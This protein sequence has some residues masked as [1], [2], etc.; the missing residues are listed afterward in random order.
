V[1]QTRIAEKCVPRRAVMRIV[2]ASRM[3]TSAV[4]GTAHRVKKTS[5]AQ[6]PFAPRNPREATP[7]VTASA[8][9]ATRQSLARSAMR[10]MNMLASSRIR[11]GAALTMPIC[12][13]D[14]PLS[15]I[16]MGK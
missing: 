6:K 12:S 10:P 4:T 13:A 16:Q 1:P 3:G 2:A 11:I 15:L 8:M 5:T 7:A 9:I 14:S